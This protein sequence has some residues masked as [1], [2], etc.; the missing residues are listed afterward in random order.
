MFHSRMIA[1]FVLAVLVAAGAGATPVRAD[2]GPVFT[3]SPV[4]Y[5]PA[6]P[7]TKSYFVINT[8]PGATVHSQVRV[9]NAGAVAGTA[10]LYPVDG[11]TGQTSGVVFLNREDPRAAAGTWLDPAL[12]TLN[13]GPGESRVAGFSVRVPAD[14]QSGQ[15][16]AGLAV[17]DAAPKQPE[18]ESSGPQKEKAGFSVTVLS[19]AVIA[20]QLNLP[21]PQV[22]ELQVSS[23]ASDGNEGYQRLLVGLKNNGNTM[24][25]PTG[26]LQVMDAGGHVLQDLPLKLDTLLPQ[27][28][29][30]YP[31]AVQNR[32]LGAG[33]YH[34]T[35]TLDYGQGKQLRASLP[36][37]ISP[38]AA[39]QVFQAPKA[40]APAGSHGAVDHASGAALMLGLIGVVLAVV[41]VGGFLL[42]H[43]NQ[44]WIS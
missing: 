24:E 12:Q 22:D 13:L 8:E 41:A 9:T 38:A 42:A 19:R 44:D 14:A 5:D 17:E 4:T 43:R 33:D 37:H 29:I 18:S 7:Q 11:A 23:I 25:K 10:R 15:H 3:L 35:L 20:V 26:S 21:G 28:A 39:A 32:A 6:L 1:V 27:T 30:D 34:T 36:L 2:S 40:L 16:V 31:V